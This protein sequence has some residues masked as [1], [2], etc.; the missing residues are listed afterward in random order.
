MMWAMMWATGM[1][2]ATAPA[3]TPAKGDG[4]DAGKEGGGLL[5]EDAVV[6]AAV[7]A[8]AAAATAAAVAAYC[9]G[10]FHFIVKIFLCGIFVCGGNWQ[11]HTS[12]HT[13]V[14]LEEPLKDKFRIWQNYFCLQIKSICISYYFLFIFGILWYFLK[15][16]F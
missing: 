2:A 12:P 14:M 7:A 13:L 5:A 8:V 3:T 9:W 11:G 4:R 16:F 1:M 10:C 15:Q 6:V